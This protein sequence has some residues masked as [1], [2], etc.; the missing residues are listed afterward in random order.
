MKRST[1]ALIASICLAVPLFSLA[2]KQVP[3]NKPPPPPFYI[4]PYRPPSQVLW[5]GALS[6]GINTVE[7]I[8]Y[9]DPFRRC[10]AVIYKNNLEVRCFA[11]DSGG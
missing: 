6:F 4:P 10:I 8:P 5:S 9:S 1:K 11:I 2:N 7:W 3:G